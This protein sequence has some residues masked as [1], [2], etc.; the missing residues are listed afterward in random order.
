MNLPVTDRDTTPWVAESEIPAVKAALSAWRALRR[1]RAAA[2]AAADSA[3]ACVSPRQL[4]AALLS[5]IARKLQ[6]VAGLEAR[7]EKEA[8]H[9]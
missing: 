4:A 2:R 6:I 5:D 1:D 3:A 9:A 8:R 7:M